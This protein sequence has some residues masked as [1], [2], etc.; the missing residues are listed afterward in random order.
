MDT[1][2][3]YNDSP[4]AGLPSIALMSLLNSLCILHASMLE[5]TLLEAPAESVRR[6]LHGFR[7]ARGTEQVYYFKTGSP[8]RGLCSSLVCSRIRRRRVAAWHQHE[9]PGGIQCSLELYKG[10]Q[11][12]LYEPQSKLLHPLP[13][14]LNHEK[15]FIMK[16]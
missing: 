14:S 12:L 6:N 7:K 8:I 3:D 2:K 10:I 16:L 13:T 9:S 15:V 4:A 11:G 1:G 5:A